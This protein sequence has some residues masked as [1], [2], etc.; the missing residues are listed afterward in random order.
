M[1]PRSEGFVDERALVVFVDRR[2]GTECDTSQHSSSSTNILVSIQL[3]PVITSLAVSTVL[4]QINLYDSA[5][6]R[7]IEYS[8][9]STQ[10]FVFMVTA[11]LMTINKRA[12]SASK[13]PHAQAARVPPSASGSF[14]SAGL[15]MCQG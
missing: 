5:W 3:I 15:L 6:S 4:V 2:M 9:S 8:K 14:C 7:R 1:R 13:V 11:H 12:T 10:A